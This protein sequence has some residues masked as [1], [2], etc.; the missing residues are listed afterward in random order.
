MSGV[1]KWFLGLA[2]ILG[3]AA[4]GC[5]FLI[6]LNNLFNA[7]ISASLATVVEKASD[8][9]VTVGESEFNLL[10]GRGTIAE[11]KIHKPGNNRDNDTITFLNIEYVLDPL[12]LWFEPT[13]IKSVEI[14][15]AVFNISIEKQFNEMSALRKT[16][17]IYAAKKD[18]VFASKPIILDRFEMP[19]N[20]VMIDHILGSRGYVRNFRLSPFRFAALGASDGGVAPAEIVR[21]VV[22]QIGSRI[23]VVTEQ[24]R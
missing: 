12:S 15:S 7:R 10:A 2:V 19:D 1:K 17:A 6:Y 4:S 14:G 22:R 8:R 20:T 18:T 21:Q 23:N 24:S 3:L 5:V 16:I 9:E 11:F 13:R